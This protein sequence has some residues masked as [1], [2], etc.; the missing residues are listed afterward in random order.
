MAK[1]PVRQ[2]KNF[3]GITKKT[4]ENIQMDAGA[5]FKNF[6]MQTDTYTTAKAAG[7]LLFATQGGNEFAATATF[8]HVEVDGKRSQIVGDAFIDDWAV[9][10]KTTAIETTVE[11]IKN[12]LGVASIDTSEVDGYTKI[13]GETYV[14]DEDYLE[15]VTWVG[16]IKGTEKPIIIQVFNAMSETGLTYTVADKG[17]ATIETTF[18]SNGTIDDYEKDDVSA[19]FAIY[20]PSTDTTTAQSETKNINN[21]TTETE[22]YYA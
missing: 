5:V 4:M 20:Y 1:V 9:T 7:K 14:L 22:D 15:N 21:T 3:N 6:D 12:A 13:T 2:F 16:R 18:T 17:N 10:L 19:P 8:R 11:A